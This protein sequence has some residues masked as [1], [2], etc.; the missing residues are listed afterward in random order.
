MKNIVE[1]AREAGSFKTL[2]A[3]AESAGLAET[4]S[5]TGPFTVFAPSDEA[6]AKLPEGAVESLLKDKEKL[7]AILKYHI[8]SGK[9]SAEAVKKQPALKTIQGK[10]LKVDLSQGVKV[11][12]ATVVK[13]DIDASNGVIHV[14]DTVLTV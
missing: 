6:F 2:L 5:G 4:L 14:I 10:D 7:S 8:V 11:G 3:A 9:M 12:T 13:T 1:T